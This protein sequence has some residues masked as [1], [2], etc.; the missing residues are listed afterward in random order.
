MFLHTSDQML[1]DF[2]INARLVPQSPS[3]VCERCYEQV[4]TNS[5]ARWLPWLQC[6]HPQ[7]H[8]HQQASRIRV[9]IG[10]GPSVVKVRELPP[11][12]LT[13]SP[14][15]LTLCSRYNTC[16]NQEN[17]TSPHSIEE[18]EYWKWCICNGPHRLGKVQYSTTH[19]H[20]FDCI[21]CF[22]V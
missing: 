19:L 13:L 18:L 4:R 7:E 11:R 22:E 12:L 3:D 10:D 6:A 8:E 15:Q 1:K 17:C 9:V 2:L 5:N 21:S 16:D 14:S 20:T